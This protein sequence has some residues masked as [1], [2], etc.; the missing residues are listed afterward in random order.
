MATIVIQTL[1]R[2][3]DHKPPPRKLYLRLPKKHRSH[4]VHVSLHDPSEWLNGLGHNII[5]RRG[6]LEYNSEML[7]VQS[8]F[9][10]SYAAFRAS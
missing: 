10:S 1:V 3:I 9:E 7:G 8:K 5:W 4:P 2:V 6:Y